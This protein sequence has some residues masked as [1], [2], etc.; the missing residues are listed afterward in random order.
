VA[1]GLVGAAAGGFVEELP[2]A[3]MIIA[4]VPATRVPVIRDI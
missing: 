4:S 3:V 2:H 1:A